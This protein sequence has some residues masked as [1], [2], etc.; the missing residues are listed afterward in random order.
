MS[1]STVPFEGDR[2]VALVFGD[3][4]QTRQILYLEGADDDVW[5]LLI[6]YKATPF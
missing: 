5:L 4:G 6:K 3:G 1:S 2:Y